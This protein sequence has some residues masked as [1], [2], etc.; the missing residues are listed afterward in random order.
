[1]VEFALVMPIFL[2]ILCG[3]LD[4][5]WL[6]YN[7]LSLNNE[8][9]EGTRYAVVNSGED[10]NADGIENHIENTMTSIFPND[11]DI[12]I[13]YSDAA[14]PLS[15]DITVRLSTYVPSLTPVFGIINGENGKEIM[16]QVV[17]KVES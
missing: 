15:G 5:G 2:L 11:V 8:C 7:Q 16:A 12:Y 9:R 14:S 6:F 17:M 1:M 4:Y 10:G 3:I 13:H